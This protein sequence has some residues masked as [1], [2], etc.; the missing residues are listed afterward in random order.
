MDCAHSCICLC[1]L[2]LP[3]SECLAQGHTAC[4][5]RQMVVLTSILP[6]LRHLEILSVVMSNKDNSIRPHLF[7]FKQYT[8]CQLLILRLC[9]H[10]SLQDMNTLGDKTSFS[11]V[12]CY[13]L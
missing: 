5:R 10:Y 13:F 3:F 7:A 4:L 9:V 12:F 8:Y 2:K 11:P 6:L 1:M